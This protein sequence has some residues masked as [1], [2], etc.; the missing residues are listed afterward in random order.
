MAQ[1]DMS[2]LARPMT[3]G[4]ANGVRAQSLTAELPGFSSL[5]LL[6]QDDDSET[7]L[8]PLQNGGGSTIYFLRLL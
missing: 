1:R 7:Q 2:P 4:E 3:R 5:P 6:L 8:L